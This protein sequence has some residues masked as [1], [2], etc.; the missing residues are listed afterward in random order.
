MNLTVVVDEDT[1]KRARIRAIQENTSV[2]AVVREFL[3][4]YAGA[5]DSGPRRA[6]ACWRC[7]N[8][9]TPGEATPSGQ[10]TSCMSVEPKTMESRIFGRLTAWRNRIFQRENAVGEREALTLYGTGRAP[11][12]T[13]GGV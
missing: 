6:S 5:I 3:A 9:A 2:N 13:G 7:P 10:G 4:A 1:L 12:S 11:T 8:P